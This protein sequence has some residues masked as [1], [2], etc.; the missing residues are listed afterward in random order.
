MKEFYPEQRWYSTMEPELGLGSVVETEGRIVKIHFSLPDI[1]RMYEGETAPLVRAYLAPGHELQT[2]DGCCFTVESVREQDH[3]YYYSGEGHEIH[4]RDLL[5]SIDIATPENRLKAGNLADYRDFKLR[6]KAHQLRHALLKSPVRGFGGIRM[7]LFDHQI[8]IAHQATSRH[9][10][11]LLLADEVGLGK[12]IEAALILHKMLLTGRIERVLILVPSA[13]IYQWFIELFKRFNLSFQV[14]GEEAVAEAQEKDSPIFAGNQLFL[15]STDLAR[16]NQPMLLEE[17]WDMVIVDEVHH[18]NYDTSL[19]EALQDLSQQ[20]PHILLLSAT[21]E[22]KSG[23]EDHFRRLQLL[24]PAR[25]HSFSEYNAEQAD[26]R[27]V[28]MTAKKLQSKQKL[29]PDDIEM[30]QSFYRANPDN[31][32]SLLTAYTAGDS[33]VRAELQQRLLDLHGI[34]RLLFRNTRSVIKGF[35]ERKCIP[36]ALTPSDGAETETKAMWLKELLKDT[37]NEKIVVICSSKNE[38][39]ILIGFLDPKG[40][41]RSKKFARFHEDMSLLERDRQAAWFFEEDGPRLLVSSPLGAEGRNFQCAHKLVLFDLPLQPEQLEQRIGRL[42]RIGQGARIEIYVPCLVGSAEER[43]FQWYDQVLDSF[44]TPWHGS[45]S[46]MKTFGKNLTVFI[47]DYDSYEWKEFL[48]EAKLYQQQLLNELENGRDILLEL[49]SNNPAQAQKLTRLITAQENDSDVEEF[50]TYALERGGVD[51]EEISPRTY[52]LRPGPSYT[53]PFPGLDDESMVISFDRPLCLEKDAVKLL[54]WDHPMVRDTIDDIITGNIGNASF[55]RMSGKEQGLILELIF[56]VETALPEYLRAERFLP[57]TPVH[58]IVDQTGRECTDDYCRINSESLEEF[59]AMSILQ[60]EDV[61][62]I[63][64]N[65]VISGRDLA[66]KH[67]PPLVKAAQAAVK[68]ELLPEIE[69]LKELALVNPSI[70]TEEVFAF[71]E[72]FD[73][74]SAGLSKTHLRL[75]ALRLIAIC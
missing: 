31:V 39:E 14:I 72:E 74:V 49:N 15:C 66:E 52:N 20:T 44:E 9:R 13:L 67:I 51:A 55:A 6:L 50:M 75:D 43:L 42:D 26:Y 64:S 41:K 37:G 40:K 5:D 16:E 19:F 73:S 45:Q 62:D 34:G 54:S 69:R 8:Y 59:D 1:I 33:S 27:A 12:T 56:L 68:S 47:N 36:V 48:A 32:K 57:P 18:V 61:Q 23:Q 4:E 28:A 3:H 21:P 70:S 7:E 24:D 11:R 25:F 63:I 53:K 35:P 65:M 58:I 71:Q 60:Q 29:S 46:I 38:V 2:R 22:Q 30:I 17:K 10:V